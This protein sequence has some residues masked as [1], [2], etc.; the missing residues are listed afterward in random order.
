MHD[1]KFFTTLIARSLA[2]TDGLPDALEPTMRQAVLS[3][4]VS[5]AALV[6]QEYE[7]MLQEEACGL[8][9]PESAQ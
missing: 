7:Q 9:H 8:L 1:N 2:R 5:A 4:V 3:L 6:I